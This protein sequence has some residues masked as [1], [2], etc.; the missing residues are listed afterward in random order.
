MRLVYGPKYGAI[1][2]IYF[3][4]ETLRFENVAAVNAGKEIK[5]ENDALRRRTISSKNF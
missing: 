4:A 3:F 5:A 1:L 2:L